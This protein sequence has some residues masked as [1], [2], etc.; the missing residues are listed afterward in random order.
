M[1]FCV[2]DKYL[3]QYG[4]PIWYSIDI[5]MKVQ[6]ITVLTLFYSD[7]S[8][9]ENCMFKSSFEL[10]LFDAKYFICILHDI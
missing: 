9:F 4:R 3:N 1:H 5:L 6:N 7:G 8:Y 10:L 2:T